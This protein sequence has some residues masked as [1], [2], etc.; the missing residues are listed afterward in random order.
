MDVR[1]LRW[2][3]G[4]TK[5]D[6]IKMKDRETTKV[7]KIANKVQEMRLQW[8]G[9]VMRREEHYVGRRAMEMEL[10][11]QGRRKRGRR[12]RRWLYR[13]GMI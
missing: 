12:K 1:M 3:C 13:V 2:M 4:V 6:K 10:G 11:L 7:W 5:R 9:H 8:Y